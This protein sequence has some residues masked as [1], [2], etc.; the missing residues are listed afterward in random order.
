MEVVQS[1]VLNEV[2][3][4]TESNNFNISTPQVS[5]AL[6]LEIENV[7][8]IVPIVVSR[9]AIGLSS[10]VS[11]DDCSQAICNPESDL[12]SC[13]SAII[14]RQG[15]SDSEAKDW[16]SLLRLVGAEL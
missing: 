4:V 14:S 2:E 1:Q 9:P 11:E 16:I 3:N 8:E 13:V 15:T 5:V 10:S 6:D 7:S 12:V